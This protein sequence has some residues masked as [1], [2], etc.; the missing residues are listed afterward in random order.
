MLDLYSALSSRMNGE[1]WKEEEGVDLF[2]SLPFLIRAFIF[3]LFPLSVNC[4]IH[5]SFSMSGVVIVDVVDH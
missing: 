2:R 4:T 5:F 1:S 3:P